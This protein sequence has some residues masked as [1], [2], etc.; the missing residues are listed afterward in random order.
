[1]WL[2]RQEAAGH[3]GASPDILA[4]HVH[5]LLAVARAFADGPHFDPDDG[6]PRAHHLLA[7]LQRRIGL[8]QRRGLD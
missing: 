5:N 1:M 7:A 3:G 8:R 6:S 4:D 2:A